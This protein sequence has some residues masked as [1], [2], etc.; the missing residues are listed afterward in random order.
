M[1]AT[2]RT[3]QDRRTPVIVGVGEVSD[4]VQCDAPAT[5]AVELMVEAVRA[6]DLDAGGGLIPAIDALYVVNSL[7]AAPEPHIKV[8][9]ALGIMP[10]IA[11]TSASPSGEM[12]ARLLND[13]AH[14]IARG[15]ASIVAITGGEALRSGPGAA[16]GGQDAMRAALQGVRPL[17][18]KYDLV[19][20]LAVYPLYEQATRAAWGQ[21]LEES[22][23]ETGEI[24][25]RMSHVAAENPH[26]WIRDRLTP[27]Q[28]V[29]AAADNPMVA[30]P[31]T[32][33]M[34]ANSRVNQ[35]AALLVMSLEQARRRRISAERMVFVGAGAAAHES[36]DYLLRPGYER[37]AGME[38]SI[39]RALS[40][41]GLT[42]QEL[43]Y[44]ELYSCFP[45]IPKMARRI[46]QWDLARPVSVYGGLTFGGGPIANCMTHAVAAMTRRLRVAGTHGLIFANG[47]FAT[48]NHTIVLSRR[49]PEPECV[50]R[51]YDCNGE[52]AARRGPVPDFIERYT[53]PA[54]LETYTIPYGRDGKP[55]H[56]T[57]VGRTPA[58]QRFLARVRADD[59]RTM[60]LLTWREREPIGVTGMATMDD[61][62]LIHWHVPAA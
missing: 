16:G 10:R 31:Y 41:N 22:L 61:Q 6:A 53:G 56:A 45:C 29:V 1:S 15:E 34:V 12:P 36:D 50:L 23:S 2:A 26:A 3:D 43:D 38:V 37:S 30:F 24:W 39:E 25:S 35:G 57:I 17:L 19:L 49:R 9:S 13:A 33:R 59:G 28:I 14:L 48:H 5:K 47:G 52:A 40:F 11:A 4:R 21:T 27:E 44:V 18:R 42:A 54:T 32:R 46:L 8:A 62:G 58:G 55:S 60:A 7:T 51:D 20:P